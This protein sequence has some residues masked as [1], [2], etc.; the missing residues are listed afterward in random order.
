M[1]R[2]CAALCLGLVVPLAQAQ[3]CAS[4]PVQLQILGSGDA[5]MVGERAGASLLV[6]VN[7]KSRIMID[8]GSGAAMRFEQ[9]GG[10]AADLE[11]ILLTHLRLARTADLPALVQSP[12]AMTRT[13]ALA[14]YGP[15]GNPA[16]PSTVS[17]VR[18]LFD[19]TLG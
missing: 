7:G 4:S 10:N 17:F 6:W 5:A 3:S 11:A 8:A 9:A 14:I 2:A 19:P 15:G 18:A 1:K 12:S 13:R 16:M